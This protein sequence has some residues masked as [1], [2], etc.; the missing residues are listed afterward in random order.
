M[1][2][3]YNDYGIVNKRN[4]LYRNFHEIDNEVYLVEI[5]RQAKK[6]FILLFP[7]YAKPEQYMIESL[8]EK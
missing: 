5:S 1:K 4:V 8:T 6:I 7:N 3:G 2:I